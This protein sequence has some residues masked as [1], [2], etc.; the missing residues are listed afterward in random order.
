MASFQKRGK[1]WQY[2]V[3]NK[4][5]PIRK[6][7]FR[8]KKE[9]QI[10]AAEIEA[11]LAKGAVPSSRKISF[12]DYFNEWVDLYKVDIANNTRKRYLNTQGVLFNYFDDKD[13]QDINKR[14]YQTFLNEYA[15]DKHRSTVKKLNTHVRG[16]VRDAVD[17]GIIRSDFTRGVV[18]SGE[19]S[20]ESDEKH[21]SYENSRILLNR[22]HN[23][24]DESL[25]NY[26]I[27]L[28]LTT[29]MRFGEI[30]GLTRSDFNFKDNTINIDKTWGY[31]KANVQ[32]FG[33]T[34]NKSSV[35]KI[36]MD[37][38]T[39]AAFKSLFKNTPD[40]I[41]RLVF[42]SPQSMYKVFTNSTV[43]NRLNSILRDLKINQITMHGLRHTHAS[44]LLYQGVSVYY[45]SER[46]G[47]SSIE[48]TMNHY[49]HLLKEL[50]EKDEN[51]TKDIFNKM[52]V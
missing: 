39:M 30:V 11:E 28:G 47:H 31:T 14:A 37:N 36:T 35:R 52:S 7:G 45:V 12:A 33:E 3:S 8:T 46:L 22:I 32:G 17:E 13:I 6:A 26:M 41:H 40:N 5:K 18:F 29:G 1:S 38:K 24:L 50:R 4:G 23:T 19:A 48:T 51:K 16:C 10:A 9:A 49:A 42:Y 20:K 44:V 15:K 25:A 43:N 34:K 27:L 2:T 21:L